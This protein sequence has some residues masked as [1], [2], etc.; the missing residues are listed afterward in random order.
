MLIWP[1][2]DLMVLF[3]GNYHVFWGLAIDV[4]VAAENTINTSSCKS[5]ASM[6]QAFYRMSSVTTQG[7]LLIIVKNE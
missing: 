4:Q 2:V 3:H 6:V 5:A 7:T 1:W